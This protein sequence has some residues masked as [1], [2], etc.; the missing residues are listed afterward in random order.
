MESP[1]TFWVWSWQATVW[2][3]DKKFWLL[4]LATVCRHNV[5]KNLWCRLP[6]VFLGS[7]SHDTVALPWQLL[8]ILHVTVHT[9][10]LVIVEKNVCGDVYRRNEILVCH[11]NLLD[12]EIIATRNKLWLHYNMVVESIASLMYI[13]HCQ[14]QMQVRSVIAST[15]SMMWIQKV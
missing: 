10:P 6:F 15:V 13:W 12:H 7:H 4:G 1:I 9:I 11:F 14:L 5:H 2:S 3:N 8:P